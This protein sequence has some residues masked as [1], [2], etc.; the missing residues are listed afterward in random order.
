MTE[1]LYYNDSFLK[2]FDA[3]VVSCAEEGEPS[4]AGKRVAEGR[5]S[6]AAPGFALN[7]KARCAIGRTVKR[8][9]RDLLCQCRDEVFGKAFGNNSFVGAFPYSA[10]VTNDTVPAP[11]C[12]D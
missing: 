5:P 4:N 12:I 7:A 10:S 8:Y 9:M 11:V 3:T 1:R 6:F 2:E